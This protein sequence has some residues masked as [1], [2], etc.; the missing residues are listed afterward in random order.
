MGDVIEQRVTLYG[1]C[2]FVRREKGIYHY[3][4]TLYPVQEARQKVTYSEIQ[5]L[6]LDNQAEGHSTR[7]LDSLFGL[8]APA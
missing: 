3:N 5:C 6:W 7:D 4:H 1:E 2:G 8:L